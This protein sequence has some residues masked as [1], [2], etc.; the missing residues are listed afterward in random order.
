MCR[1]GGE[2]IETMNKETFKLKYDSELQMAY[3]QKVQDE[4][5]KNHQESNTEIITG[6]IPQLL[7]VD[8]SVHRLCPVRSF[9]NYLNVLNPR[10]D[11]LWQQPKNKI[12]AEG[13]WY[14]AQPVGHNPIEK[15]MG[16]I[17]DMMKETLSQRYTNH[18]IRVTG[19]T[20]LSKLY[21]AKQ[22]MSITGHKSLDSLA[23]Y[24]RVRADE[25]MC[26]GLSLTYS[27]LKPEETRRIQAT[28]EYKAIMMGEKIPKTSLP[29]AANTLQIRDQ[30]LQKSPE[31]H[32]MDP[33][34][35]QIVDLN[36]ALETYVPPT[37]QSTPS[38]S[39]NFD[40]LQ[41]M[42]DLEG[43][44]DIMLAASQYE[45]SSNS[46]TTTSKTAVVQKKSSPRVPMPMFAGCR[47]GNIGTL[48]IHIHKN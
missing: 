5:T 45:Q 25:K 44:N 17:S 16:R 38:G 39:P 13:P 14:N 29:I 8:G 9:E 24:Q 7:D 47:F 12:P 28:E 43:D 18:C 1:R 36:N 15:F 32:A 11:A 34:N 19:T 4:Q 33:K 21:N 42:S 3:V 6:F 10:C 30:P 46:T 22:V 37:R 31:R 20:N 26:M 40:I 2:N 23:I 41:L 27:L 48:N 35:N